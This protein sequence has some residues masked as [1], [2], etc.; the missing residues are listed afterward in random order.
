MKY[1]YEFFLDEKNR[2]VVNIRKD[3]E[4]RS[5]IRFALSYLYLKGEKW[6]C[7]ARIDNHTHKGKK[8]MCHIHRINDK[9]VQYEDLT[10]DEAQ[11][12]L[13]NIGDNLRG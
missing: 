6:V 10:V 1:K 13:I 3:K 11:E 9:K 12:K 5:K 8:D 7:L 2:I 4:F